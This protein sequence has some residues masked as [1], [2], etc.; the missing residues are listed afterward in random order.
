MSVPCD[1]NFKDNTVGVKKQPKC[2]KGICKFRLREYFALNIEKNTQ[3]ISLP[4]LV[5]EY[6]LKN[7]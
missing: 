4:L 2:V 1:L 6:V 7:Y 3:P 5:P